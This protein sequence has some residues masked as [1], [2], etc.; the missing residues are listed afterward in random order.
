MFARKVLH[1]KFVELWNA[2]VSSEDIAKTF[3]ISRNYV[4]CYAKAHRDDCPNRKKG[5]ISQIDHDKFVELW[6]S[7]VSVEKMSEI[8]GI[9]RV[10]VSRYAMTCRELCGK[11]DPKGRPQSYHD[12]FTKMW[13]E[14]VEAKK[15]AKTLNISVRAVY[16]HARL[17][18]GECDY[19]RQDRKRKID[20]EIFVDL[21]N[22]DVSAHDIAELFGVTVHTVYSYASKNRRYC[23]QRSLKK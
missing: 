11:R 7:G 6:N 18:R 4:I 12:Q 9:H 21:W 2:G 14:G 22:K 10:S 19:R 20:R 5:R 17:H 16:Q 15:I 23:K 1:E 3:D 8:L 13:N